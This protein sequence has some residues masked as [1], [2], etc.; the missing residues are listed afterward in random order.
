MRPSPARRQGG[1]SAWRGEASP[2]ASPWWLTYKQ[3]TE[4]GAQV[5]KGEHGTPVFLWKTAKIRLGTAE[6]RRRAEQDGLKIRRDAKGEYA[7]AF[8]ART[9]TVF[10]ASQVDGLDPKLTPTALV[11]GGPGK[12]SILVFTMPVWVLLMGWP[13]LGERVRGLQWVAVGLALGDVLGEEIAHRVEVL[14]ARRDGVDD[15]QQDDREQQAAEEQQNGEEPAL[16]LVH[17]GRHDA[18]QR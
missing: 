11:D 7:E 15:H 9:Y 12:T 16:G 1:I 18:R 2:T 14:E 6:K 4:R 3:A 10:N 13:A 8:M 17:T 5:R